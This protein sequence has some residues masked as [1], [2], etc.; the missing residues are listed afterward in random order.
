M[1]E[2]QSHHN[3][4]LG[5]AARLSAGDHRAGRRLDPDAA[6]QDI[7]PDQTQAAMLLGAARKLTAAAA[8]EIPLQEAIGFALTKIGDVLA[9]ETGQ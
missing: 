2:Q 4:A 3:P 5:A 9:Q 7:E 6:A 1:N 8:G